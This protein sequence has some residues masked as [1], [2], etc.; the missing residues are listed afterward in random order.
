LRALNPK[1]SQLSSAAPGGAD[2]EL[3]PT[4]WC[5]DDALAYRIWLLLRADQ[6]GK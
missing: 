6:V 1:L 2:Y 5:I 4:Q 3:S